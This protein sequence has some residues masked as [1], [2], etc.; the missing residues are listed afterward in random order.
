MK[1]IYRGTLGLATTMDVYSCRTNGTSFL[2]IPPPTPS[3]FGNSSWS[4][5]NLKEWFS[6]TRQILG[7]NLCSDPNMNSH[8]IYTSPDLLKAREGFAAH[9]VRS[10]QRTRRWDWVLNL[11]LGVAS[12]IKCGNRFGKT[13]LN[14]LA[15]ALQSQQRNS[16]LAGC[17]GILTSPVSIKRSELGLL[18]PILVVEP[19]WHHPGPAKPWC[20]Y[21]PTRQSKAQEMPTSFH[22]SSPRAISARIESPVSE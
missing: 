12:L 16:L 21:D 2:I 19:G 4:Q 7:I 9:W 22:H 20:S 14:T 13:N 3:T 10:K 8:E 1:P 18:S 11:P 5:P 6:E 17:S 15:V